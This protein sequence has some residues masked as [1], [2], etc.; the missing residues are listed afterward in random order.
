MKPRVLVLSAS[1][2]AG[3]LR[4]AE[5]VGAGFAAVRPRGGSRKPRR[6]RFYQRRVSPFYGQA[7]LDL[8]NYFPHF[9]GYFYIGSKGTATP[10][11]TRDRLRQAVQKLNM[12]SFEKF[13][14]ENWQLVINTHFLPADMIAS[15]ATAAS[16]R[17]RKR[18]SAP[19]STRTGCGSI[20]P[21]S[22]ISPPAK[23]RSICSITACRP[24]TS[25]SRASRSIRFLPN[26]S[27]ARPVWPGKD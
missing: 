12:R 21:A 22:A 20:S 7:Y 6:A 10:A 4:A 26:P 13:V 14:S 15:S 23:V 2:G 8:V 25:K 19:I 5:A 1:V 3:H 16:C 27:I 11:A 18:R 9:V 24:R 17:C